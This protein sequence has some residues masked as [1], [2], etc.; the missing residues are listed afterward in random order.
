MTV[1]GPETKNI[2]N[3]RLRAK[4]TRFLSTKLEDYYNKL[5]T[6]AIGIVFDNKKLDRLPVGDERIKIAKILEARFLWFDDQLEKEILKRFGP[7]LRIRG[8]RSSGG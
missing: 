6:E 3:S 2:V 5:R 1:F 4:G 8:S 7:F